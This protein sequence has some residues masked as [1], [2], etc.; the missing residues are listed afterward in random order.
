[1]WGIR[2]QEEKEMEPFVVAL[3]PFSYAFTRVHFLVVVSKY[4]SDVMY[5]PDHLDNWSGRPMSNGVP[6]WVQLSDMSSWFYK[7]VIDTYWK[8]G[9]RLASLLCTSQICL[10]MCWYC[11]INVLTSFYKCHSHLCRCHASFGSSRKLL[12]KNWTQIIEHESRFGSCSS[13]LMLECSKLRSRYRNLN[14]ND[15]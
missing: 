13:S 12:C 5:S 3:F 4:I 2:R 11:F 15:V 9:E 6:D 1:M 10:F 8:P 7:L 14:K